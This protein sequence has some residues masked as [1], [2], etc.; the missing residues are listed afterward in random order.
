MTDATTFVHPSAVVE[1][2]VRLGAGVRVWHRSRLRAGAQVG[3]HTRIGEGVHIGAGVRIGANCKIQDGAL[4]YEGCHLEDGVFIGPGVIVTNDRHPRAVN[5]DGSLRTDEDWTLE[6]VVVETGASIGAGAL[7]LA[8]VR[9]GRWAV[10]GAG[11]LV[12]HD[13]APHS[14][15]L[16]VPARPVGSVC[17][18]GRRCT[19]CGTCGWNEGASP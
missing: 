4:L 6:G 10:V 18:C 16:G 13:V 12:T 3:D 9:I 14:L 7:I 15:V 17:F 1:D 5:P 2:G 11:S 19:G 8:G